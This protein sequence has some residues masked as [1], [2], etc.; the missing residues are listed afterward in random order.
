MEGKETWSA[1]AP[2]EGPVPRTQGEGELQEQA[3]PLM[4][5]YLAAHAGA[6]SP[7]GVKPQPGHPAPAVVTIV[8]SQSI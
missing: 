3:R 4:S 1:A 7:P 8:Q 6:W 2:V 5:S